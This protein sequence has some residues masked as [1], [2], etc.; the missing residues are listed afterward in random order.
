MSF[1]KVVLII[2]ITDYELISDDIRKLNVPGVTV[3]RVQGY[4]DYTNEFSQ[5]GLCESLKIE[6]YTTTEHAEQIANTLSELAIKMTEGGGVIAIEP[7]TKVMNVK[8]LERK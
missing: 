1:S 5:E 7:V 4:G 6:I 3:K 8:K 2:N